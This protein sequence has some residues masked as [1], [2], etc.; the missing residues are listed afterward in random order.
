MTS[1]DSQPLSPPA[2]DNPVADPNGQEVERLLRERALRLAEAVAETGDEQRVE[3]LAVRLGQEQ[4]AIE[5]RVL[6]SVEPARGLTRV[7]CTSPTVAGV[8]NVRGE[9]ITVLDLAR[10]L[11]LAGASSSAR[12][13]VLVADAAGA[14]VGLL[15]DAVLGVQSFELDRL[16]P[17]LSEREFVRGILTTAILLNLEDLLSDA[18]FEVFEE[19]NEE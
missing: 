3:V 5:L 18:R 13:Y 2:Q 9:V 12:E 15:V 19:I 11:G 8:Q 6:H 1:L 10:V 16:A 17:P 4:Y 14:R 7:P